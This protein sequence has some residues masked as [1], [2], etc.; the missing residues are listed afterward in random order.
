MVEAADQG[1]YEGFVTMCIAALHV[2]WE[3]AMIEDEDYCPSLEEIDA[4][5][6]FLP[7]FEQKNFVP[8]RVE[9]P[10]GQLSYPVLSDELEQFL[11]A[12]YENGFVSS[13]NWI[14]W[15]QEAQCYLVQSDLLGSAELQVIRNLITV[16]VRKERFCE[17]HLPAMV[18][19]GHITA[20]LHRLKELR[21]N[22]NA[23]FDL[24]QFAR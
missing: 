15:Q 4:V 23:K 7:V 20:I 13:F 10:P 5:L 1:V 3:K 19:N 22:L 9:A 21:E 11:S 14:A 16:H 12:V 17:G 6:M 8:S 2:K 18:E 24:T